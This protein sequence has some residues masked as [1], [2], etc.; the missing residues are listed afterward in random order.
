MTRDQV[1]LLLQQ[2]A[3]GKRPLEGDTLVFTRRG[4]T[5]SPASIQEAEPEEPI[6]PSPGGT[7]IIVTNAPYSATGDGTTDDTAAIQAAIDAAGTAG[8]GGVFF[9]CGTYRISQLRVKTGVW[10]IGEGWCSSLKALDNNHTVTLTGQ[11]TGSNGART[12]NDTSSPP[13]TLNGHKNFTIFVDGGLGSGQ[14]RTVTHAE[15]TSQLAIS[16]DWATVPDATSTYQLLNG[17]HMIVLDTPATT[18]SIA[19][20]DLMIDGNRSNQVALVD[21]VY[22]DNFGWSN[23]NRDS[24][25]LMRNVLIENCLG[26][27]LT[28][29]TA[30]REMRIEFCKFNLCG[31]YG[32]RNL[33]DQNDSGASD[34]KFVACVASK[35][36]LSGFSCGAGHDLLVDCKSFG[37]GLQN[38]AGNAAGYLIFIDG[39]LLSAC[40]AQENFSRGFQLLLQAKS[41]G[42]SACN[43]DANGDEA[44]VLDGTTDTYVEVAVQS[45][46]ALLYQTDYALKYSGGAT[47]NTVIVQAQA[48]QLAIGLIEPSSAFN[49]DSTVIVNNIW[50]GPVN[51]RFGALGAAFNLHFGWGKE[52]AGATNNPYYS[53]VTDDAATNPTTRVQS[54]IGATVREYMKLDHAS[55]VLTLG[56]ASVAVA[57]AGAVAVRIGT[58][59]STTDSHFIWGKVGS[60]ASGNPEYRLITSNHADPRGRIEGYN[61]TT[62]RTYIDMDAQSGGLTVQGVAP[63]IQS[64]S[65]DMT[66]D[67]T[68]DVVCE[69]TFRISTGG[70]LIIDGTAGSNPALV[71]FRNGSSTR[72]NAGYTAEAEGGG[73]AGGFY[74][75]SAFDDSGTFVF[76][77][78]E[79]S[80]TGNDPVRIRVNGSLKQITQGAND[81]GGA[82][83][84]LLRVTN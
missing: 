60:P 76:R 3:G 22:L 11:S 33:L 49:F 83:F 46:A 29:T 52:D 69:T 55:A 5:F 24:S 70:D 6:P 1:E 75:I 54:S 47:R 66:F 68:G 64:L 61:G 26:T 16:D 53:I 7:W 9:P 27:G 18:A 17:K 21:G 57:F 51:T 65:G 67:S 73:D 84:A 41:C 56:S 78:F 2:A 28:R 63:L 20:V 58:D 42:L 72:W 31:E 48:G 38:I 4:W 32:S 15:T 23:P 81:S 37:N 8:G 35:C 13:F 71:A 19:I 74:G 12:L 36:G 59:G 39:V 77:V 43:A 30:C 62:T 40:E 79:A 25:H 14:K 82:G 80:R 10:L 34:C 50:H 44:V 45:T